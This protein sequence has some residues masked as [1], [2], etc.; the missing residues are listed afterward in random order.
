MVNPIEKAIRR[1]DRF[2]QGHTVPSFVFGVMKKFGDDSAG[3]LAALIAYYGFLSLFPL[4]LVLTTLLGI[5]FSHDAALQHRIIDSAVSQFPIVGDQLKGPHGVSSLRAGSGVGLAVGLVGLVW[6]S[7]GVSQAAQR[8]MAEV[9]NVP[10]VIRPG[11]LP[12]LGRNMEFLAIL[13]L[14]VV[15]TTF[16]AGKVT[17]GHGPLWSQTLFGLIGVLVSVL[18]YVLGFRVLTPKSIETKCLVPGAI[19]AG[20]GWTVLQYAGTLL[21]GHTLRHSS[22]VYGYFGSVLGLISF[23]FLAAELT[24]YSAEV[25]VVRMRRLYPRSIAPPPLT[26]ADRAVLSAIAQQGE[27]RPE[28][29]VHVEFP[30][31]P[32]D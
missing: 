31:A 17:L 27:R 2:Q 10:G 8:A 5:F 22:Q 11:F 12:R 23:L 18:L 13:A 29:R 9:W 3:T 24:I 19:L 1:V 7:F 30:P 6:G 28:Q 15:L 16:L 4:L 20:V 25:N 26:P 14:D 32:D 21:V